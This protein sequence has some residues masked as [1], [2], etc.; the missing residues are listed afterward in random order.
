M[1]VFCVLEKLGIGYWGS[2]FVAQGPAKFLG[3]LTFAMRRELF[4]G[5]ETADGLKL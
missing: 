2:V 4:G 1:G 3:A 5:D